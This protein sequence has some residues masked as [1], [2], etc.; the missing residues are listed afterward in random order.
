MTTELCDNSNPTLSLSTTSICFVRFRSILSIYDD[1]PPVT[2]PE[3]FPS[4]SKTSEPR[5]LQGHVAF[6]LQ[7]FRDQVEALSLCQ[8]RTPP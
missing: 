3:L 1:T 2:N 5:F 7:S 8:I 6:R 4:K